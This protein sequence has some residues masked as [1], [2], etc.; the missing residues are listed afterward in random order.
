MTLDTAAA[1]TAQPALLDADELA[2][3][4]ASGHRL[5]EAEALAV[6]ATPDFATLPLVGA[7]GTL[8]RQHFGNTV[9]VNYLVNLKSG[10]CPEDCTYCSQRLGSKAEILKYTWLKPDEAVAQAGYG[11]AG[12]ASRVCMVASGKGPT[13]RDVD[14]VAT[15][16]EQLKGEHPQVEVCACLG[17]LKDG[18]AARLKDAGADAYNHNLN[19]SESLYPEICTSHSYQDR[20]DTV[21]QAQSAG[22][23]SCSGLIVGL[24]ETPEQLVEAVFAL[25]ELGSDSIPVNFLMP[26]DGTPMEGT[27]LLTPLACLRILA[28]VRL[29]CPDKELRIAGG[30]EMHLRSLQSTALE[31]ANSIFLGDYLT[32]EGQGAAKD[33]DMIADAGFVVLGQEASSPADVARRL[34]EAAHAAAAHEEQAPAGGCASG[35][36]TGCGPSASADA[37]GCGSA[38]S[39]CW[40]SAARE[41]VLRRRGAGTQQGP[42]A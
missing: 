4:I 15:M 2:A 8:R 31:V 13:D 22:L 41:P 33:L 5:T 21:Q 42:N 27:W 32:S 16:V 14:R 40:P 37:P 20:V 30:R 19:T 39:G 24:G 1:E 6:L 26:F 3:R 38:A 17:I 18:Q 28:L 12:G 11:I 34:R 23:S 25:R 29:A 35:C 36:G 7:A 10:L 9:K